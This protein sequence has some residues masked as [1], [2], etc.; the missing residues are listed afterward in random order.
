MDPSCDYILDVYNE[1][2]FYQGKGVQ[3]PLV[4]DFLKFQ[5]NLMVGRTVQ[6]VFN[7]FIYLFGRL[8]VEIDNIY[9]LFKTYTSLMH[10]CKGIWNPLKYPSF[11]CLGSET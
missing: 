3:S 5:N 7:H 6:Y 8:N 11:S 10:V 9:K 4:W 2:Q 1:E